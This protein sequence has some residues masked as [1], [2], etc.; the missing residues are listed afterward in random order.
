MKVKRLGEDL[1][2]CFDNSD[3]IADSFASVHG[4]AKLI[5]GNSSSLDALEEVARHEVREG[6]FGVHEY[7]VAFLLASFDLREVVVTS[8]AQ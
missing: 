4:R 1:S 5:S 3:I 7:L 2:P 8:H 6:R